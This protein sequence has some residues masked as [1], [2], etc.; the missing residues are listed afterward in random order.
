MAIGSGPPPP[1]N[2]TRVPEQTPK[3]EFLRR[4]W[5]K[6]V[7]LLT[8]RDRTRGQ[9]EL[10]WGHRLLSAWREVDRETV[11]KELLDAESRVLQDPEDV[12][13]VKI[14]LFFIFTDL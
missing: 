10:H 11:S 14:R 13:I 3:K 8:H 5:C 6:Q 4:L 7:V 2:P 1:Q 12:A 9:K